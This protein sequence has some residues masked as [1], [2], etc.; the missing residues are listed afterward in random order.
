MWKE[1][2][3]RFSYPEQATESQ[4]KDYANSDSRLLSSVFYSITIEWAFALAQQ[5]LGTAG[6]NACRSFRRVRQL[7]DEII[8]AEEDFANGILTYPILYSLSSPKHGYRMRRLL[9]S[10]W[11]PSRENRM[12]SNR[13]LSDFR[14]I[15]LDADAYP[16]T[17]YESFSHLYKVMQFVM[18]RF[19]AEQAFAISLLVNQRLTVLLKRADNEWGNVLDQYRPKLLLRY[20]GNNF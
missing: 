9:A 6:K 14:S 12:I 8:D 5:Q 13:L 20:T 1:F 11:H 10:A 16:A 2:T 18:K 17:A 7:N 19:A 4:L 3:E 15:M